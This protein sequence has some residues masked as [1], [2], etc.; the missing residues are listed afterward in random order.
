MSRPEA[1]RIIEHQRHAYRVLEYREPLDATYLY[2]MILERLTGQDKGEHYG[3]RVKSPYAYWREIGEHYSVCNC[4]NELP[5]CSGVRAERAV[6]ESVEAMKVPDGYC[7]SC[8]E[9]ITRRQKKYVFLGPNL[10]N[11]FGD[12]GVQFHQRLQCR[13]SAAEYEEK[14]VNADPTRER[15]LLTL[16]CPGHVIVHHDG[17]GECH[18]SDG[19][20][21]PHIHARHQ[22]YSAC[23]T[24]SR[25]CEEECARAG[26]PG[27]RLHPDLKHD[28]TMEGMIP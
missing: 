5:P 28:G 7:P 2:E 11:P 16:R 10:L 15:S 9:P 25:G 1:G 23:Y 22:S 3:I 27:T 13:S 17:T 12:D 21:C 4:C 8:K 6:Q 19:A 26:H 18:R 24:E 14:W 20:N